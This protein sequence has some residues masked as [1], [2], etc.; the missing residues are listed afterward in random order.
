MTVE[1]EL[2]ALYYPYPSPQSIDRIKKALLLFDHIYFVIP[3]DEVSYH[4]LGIERSRSDGFTEMHH[5]LYEPIEKGIFRIISPRETVSTFGESMVE[6]LREDK[7][8]PRIVKESLGQKD[9]LIY[10]EKIPEGLDQV[11]Y[12][13]D[14]KSY[15]DGR[16]IRLPFLVGESIMISHAIYACHAKR[17]AGEIISP[18]TDE[19]VHQKL[20]RFRLERGIR[21]LK[22]RTGVEISQDMRKAFDMAFMPIPPGSI[23][24]VV[25]LRN[26]NSRPLEK[27]RRSVKK[28]AHIMQ[29]P[30]EDYTAEVA[31]INHEIKLA[32]VEMGLMGNAADV[33]DIV[34]ARVKHGRFSLRS[35]RGDIGGYAIP[36]VIG[37]VPQLT[38]GVGIVTETNVENALVTSTDT[39]VSR[40]VISDIQNLSKPSTTFQVAFS[41]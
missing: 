20:L 27:I 3:S 18:I 1:G 15:D 17:K 11:F 36:P 31:Q 13:A 32:Y 34:T 23:Q 24:D 2:S 33:K 38:L 40:D 26:N 10:P 21:N 6:V 16:R 35:R 12:H 41:N 37:A 14:L 5:L 19:Q 4:N 22:A 8:D 30:P 39:P 25:D 29:N 9:W 28:L 7:N